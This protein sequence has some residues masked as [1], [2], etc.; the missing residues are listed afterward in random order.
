MTAAA[1]LSATPPRTKVDSLFAL[2]DFACEGK[3]GYSALF[4]LLRTAAHVSHKV[5]KG[6]RPSLPSD[7][8]IS[9]LCSAA[10]ESCG[11]THDEDIHKHGFDA[12][13]YSA[14]AVIKF[15]DYWNGILSQAPLAEG[16]QWTDDSFS[17]NQSAV[18]IKQ[19]DFSSG[20]SPYCGTHWTTPDKRDPVG[21]HHWANVDDIS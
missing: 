13:V 5:S 1:L 6:A 9:A 18:F 20:L 7:A 14:S 8:D 12:F 19:G 2:Y 21:N 17:A 3:L 11:K 15:L 16:Q 10:F 4:L